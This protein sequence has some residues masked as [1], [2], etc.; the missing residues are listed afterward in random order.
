MNKNILLSLIV[1]CVAF[2]ISSNSAE[3]GWWNSS[4]SYYANDSVLSNAGA[5]LTN[6]PYLANGSFVDTA[7]LV[8]AGKLRSDC[9][10]LVFVNETGDEVAYEFESYYDGTY[11]CNAANTVI[12]I[13]PNLVKTDNSTKVS[14]YYGNAGET[15][16]HNNTVGVW[17]VS[18][19]GRWHL[20]DADQS[21]AKDSTSNNKNFTL[22]T[23]PTNSQYAGKFGNAI[24]FNGTTGS[25]GRLN[26]ITFQTIG[27]SGV[28]STIEFWFKTNS[29]NFGTAFEKGVTNN[30]I[31]IKCHVTSDG[32]QFEKWN[33]A[34]D[35][36]INSGTNF[37]DNKWHYVVASLD[38]AKMYLYV[39]GKENGTA[40]VTGDLSNS[41]KLTIGKRTDAAGPYSGFMDELRIQNIN[42]TYDYIQ[43]T[44]EQGLA[45]L[46]SEQT[47]PVV[48]DPPLW[49]NNQ[50]SIGWVN[51]VS[52]FNTT[53]TD[54]NDN[55]GFNFSFFELGVPNGTIANYTS[56]R[57]PVNVSHYNLTLTN[58]G[59]YNW[60]IYAND[61]SN[62]WNKTDTV[63]FSITND[64]P[65]W[66]ANAS[67]L[68]SPV[69]FSSGNSYGFQI[70]WTDSNSNFDNAT[71]EFTFP[72]S[73]LVN[74]TTATTPATA[75]DSTSGSDTWYINL[76][77]FDLGMIPGSFSWKFYGIDSLGAEN[78]S[79][80]YAWN[81]SILLYQIA[82]VEVLNSTHI[83]HNV[84]I[85][86]NN[87]M[88]SLTEVNVTPDPDLGVEY[89]IGSMIERQ[90]HSKEFSIESSRSA[91]DAWLILDSPY[92]SSGGNGKGNALQLSI[93]GTTGDSGE[94]TRV[95]PIIVP[96][97]SIY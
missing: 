84:S 77:L 25:Y 39:D 93:P 36:T 58:A 68:A 2:S 21:I 78:S 82:Q 49:S 20:S 74:Y 28:S 96:S 15:S 27:T 30:I 37:S 13:N 65:Q 47:P 81:V 94:V 62:E 72:N 50:S 80:T 26:D 45:S 6:F 76:S 9:N 16:E 60:T 91:S 29:T 87:L 73:T 69:V 61:S 90:Y 79:D 42:V 83:K 5:D 89:E 67:N 23:N 44:Y 63:G 12:W 33:G 35:D 54:D 1:V 88:N 34:Q 19:L 57:I 11:G 41:D 10:D 95:C 66:I 64:L 59:D 14:M 7:A 3:A 38:S 51:Q 24:Y 52:Y 46:G 53:W 56:L 17:N 97:E 22:Y 32:I 92:L 43:R 86:T 75:N 18:Y 71:F 48:N 4:W 70:N 55:N 85:F 8:T 31:Q 40:A